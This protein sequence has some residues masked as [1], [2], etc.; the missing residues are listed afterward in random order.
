[1]TMIESLK[2]YIS[3]GGT[4]AAARISPMTA[5]D[6]VLK[7]YIVIQR[8]SSNDENV[9]S[10]SSGLYNTRLQFDYYADTYAEVATLAAQIDVLMN[11]WS[12]QNV[13]LG[14]QDLYEQ[15]VKL[16]RIQA[17]YSIWHT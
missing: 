17:D 6:L 11:A 16:Y 2:S 1:M 13:S 10:G 15:D 3:A 9:L 7:P 5:P 4:L 14:Q 8:V 12:V